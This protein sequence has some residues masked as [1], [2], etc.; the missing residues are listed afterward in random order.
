[1]TNK[2][3]IRCVRCGAEEKDGLIVR[4][5]N[6][7]KNSDHTDK[8]IPIGYMCN[9]CGYSNVDKTSNLKSI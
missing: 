4:I 1:M 9:R 8:T 6:H 3:N 2:N 5:E 7:F